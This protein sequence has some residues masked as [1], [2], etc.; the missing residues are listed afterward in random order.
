MAETED[1]Q[2]G[3]S[4]ASGE[5]LDNADRP[6]E[7][8]DVAAAGRQRETHMGF[9][10]MLATIVFIIALPIALVTTNVRCC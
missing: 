2:G 8:S 7:N 1:T 9:A 5:S 4:A 6:D 10:R 3:G